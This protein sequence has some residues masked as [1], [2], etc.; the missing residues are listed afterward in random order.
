MERIEKYYEEIGKIIKD[1][2]FSYVDKQG[3]LWDDRKKKWEKKLIT[4]LDDTSWQKEFLE[5]K[6]HSTSDVRLL[7]QGAKGFREAWHLGT[8]HE[9]YKIMKR[10]E[11]Q[12][13]Q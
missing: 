5:M 11:H 7:M 12:Q 4:K 10:R 8:L 9:E 3:E 1:L 2:T 6:S 13:Q